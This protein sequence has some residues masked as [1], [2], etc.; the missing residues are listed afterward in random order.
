M[1]IHIDMRVYVHVCKY[2]IVV[3]C[4]LPAITSVIG[5]V[6]LYFFVALCCVLLRSIGLHRMVQ[7]RT[8][9]Y[10]SLKMLEIDARV[11]VRTYIHVDVDTLGRTS[12]SHSTIRQRACFQHFIAI[13]ITLGSYLPRIIPC[14]NPC[15]V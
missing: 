10:V 4:N 13:S 8:S 7:H 1:F 12:T 5:H 2:C 14:E 9:I 6:A 15:L 3:S 11:D